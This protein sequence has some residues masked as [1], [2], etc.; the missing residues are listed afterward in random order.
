MS[1]ITISSSF[2]FGKKNIDNFLEGDVYSIS[3]EEAI[4]RNLTIIDVRT[5]EEYNNGSVPNALNFPIF[6]NL[7]R[8]E[9]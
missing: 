5:Y 9:I 6:D 2:K 7:E 8:A 4:S 1:N 3:N